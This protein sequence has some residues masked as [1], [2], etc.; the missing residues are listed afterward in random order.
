MQ[1]FV[2]FFR[3]STTKQ[4]QSGLG[5]EAQRRS[6]QEYIDQ[7]GGKI[8]KEYVE[9]ESGGKNEKDRPQLQSA[10]NFARRKKITLVFAKLDRMARDTELAARILNSNVEVAFCDMPGANRFILDVMAAVGSYERRAISERTRKAMAVARDQGRK[11]GFALHSP[12]IQQ[13][14][15]AKGAFVNKEKSDQFNHDLVWPVIRE[16]Q[17]SGVSTFSAIAEELNRRNVPTQRGGR[18]WPASV[19]KILLM[20][21]G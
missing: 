2:T 4:G 10:L 5:L 12:E 16:I 1:E 7:L 19:R 8:V 20:I 13:R 17:K 9:I 14:A 6:V 3:V 11:F 21:D 18:W 15:C